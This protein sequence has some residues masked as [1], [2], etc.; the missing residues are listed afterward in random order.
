MRLPPRH[1]LS[2]DLTV[3]GTAARAAEHAQM[4]ILA[5]LVVS[6]YYRKWHFFL[7]QSRPYHAVGMGH[8][9]LCVSSSILMSFSTLP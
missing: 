9:Q 6:A 5:L 1:C 2:R 8:M 4:A 7:K 3:D